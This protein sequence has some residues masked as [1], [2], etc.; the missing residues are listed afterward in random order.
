MHVIIL[1]IIACVISV[2]IFSTAIFVY[3]YTIQDGK[4]IKIDETSILQEK[5]YSQNF[6]GK[7]IFILGSSLVSAANAEYIEN[8]LLKNEQDYKIYNLA[9]ASDK[10]IK[11][12]NT[13]D[14]VIKAKPDIV[15]YGIGFSDV[16][17]QI[18]SEYL[19]SEVSL[20]DP[21]YFFAEFLWYLEM[22][23]ELNFN[24]L[25][26]TRTVSFGII[27]NILQKGI[28][29][30]RQ[31]KELIEKDYTFPNTP[32]F[33][34]HETDR[35]SMNEKEIEIQIKELPLTVINPP[36]KN[37]NVIALKRTIDMLQENNI[38]VII[39]TT[40]YNKLFYEIS[41]NYDQNAFNAIVEDLTKNTNTKINLLH[42]KYNDTQIW[43]GHDHLVVNKNLTF[44]SEDIAKIIL[45]EI[46][47]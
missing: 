47:P 2:G 32:F 29:N 12:L 6:T 44:Y 30:P 16:Y 11:R 26:S 18:S 40:P 5:F 31:D 46:N 38:Q 28:I 4:L 3:Q 22:N 21:R 45:N 20:P 36:Q 24:V 25:S 13:I 14:S 42:N 7:K 19:K 33:T 1:I 43:Q 39:F 10:P 35:I 9:I 23:T 15:V 8:Y 41:P 34:Y 27:D 17:D 37:K